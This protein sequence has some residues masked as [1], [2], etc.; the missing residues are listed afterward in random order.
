MFWRGRC[1]GGADVL[2]G[3]MFWRDQCFSGVDVFLQLMFKE[4]TL[5]E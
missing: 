5:L 1:F 3:P 4:P 2:E